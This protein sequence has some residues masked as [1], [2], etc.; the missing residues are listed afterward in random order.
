MKYS[1]IFQSMDEREFGDIVRKLSDAGVILENPEMSSRRETQDAVIAEL[2]GTGLKRYIDNIFLEE[3]RVLRRT[4]RRGGYFPGEEKDKIGGKYVDSLVRKGLLFEGR[5]NNRDI[6]YAPL[7]VCFSVR[8]DSSDDELISLMA[9]M[10]RYPAVFIRYALTSHWGI[11]VT[12]RTKTAAASLLYEAI[13]GGYREKVELSAAENKILH[14]IFLSG[15]RAPGEELYERF[16]ITGEKSSWYHRENPLLDFMNAP[17]VRA[18]NKMGDTQKAL[19]GLIC[20]G[21]VSAVMSD[22]YSRDCY[23]TIPLEIFSAVSEIYLADM[24]EKRNKIAREM[25]APEPAGYETF[26]GRIAGDLIKLQVARECGLVE[27]TKKEE[28]KKRSLS[29]LATL[30]KADRVYI[31]IILD[32][33][34]AAYRDGSGVEYD[35]SSILNGMLSDELLK[36]VLGIICRLDGWVYTDK[37]ADYLLNHRDLYWIARRLDRGVI[38]EYLNAGYVC[39][40]I[41][42]TRDSGAV[43]KSRLLEKVMSGGSLPPVTVIPEKEK[44]VVVQPNLEILVPYNLQAG[45]ISR[46]SEFSDMKVLDRVIHF[47]LTKESLMKGFDNGWDTG[48]I[49]EYLE[50]V[51]GSPVPGTVSKFL[52]TTG[53]KRGEVKLFSCSALIK[54]SG[55]GLSESIL[56]IKNLEAFR[57]EGLEDYLC[58]LDKPAGKVEAILKKK[59]IFAEIVPLLNTGDRKI[60]DML[61]FYSRREVEVIITYSEG[62]RRRETGSVLI[63]NIDRDFVYLFNIGGELDEDDDMVLPLGSIMD[64][65]PAPGEDL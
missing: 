29:R 44:A 27:M 40:F 9:A 24:D 45:A 55:L 11:K 57:I 18:E 60:T 25:S 3:L 34:F 33:L 32:Y 23:F 46:I 17:S 41:D 58:V 63:D 53:G 15:S 39:G 51:S 48:E 13:Q 37:L 50:D 35:I 19:L 8:Y 43:R 14:Y 6:I 38:G 21:V 12:A 2:S 22:M 31:E 64:L 16:G 56:S 20:R 28:F 36:T 1:D 47:T 10:T 59:G 4:V 62:G 30:M 61:K 26:S 52:E 42:R 65:R 49:K 54:C 5:Y 7:E